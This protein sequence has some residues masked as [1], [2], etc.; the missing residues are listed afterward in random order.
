MAARCQQHCKRHAPPALLLHAF[1]P[2]GRG[3]AAADAW[4]GCQQRQQLCGTRR[5]A[6]AAALLLECM[7][8][9]ASRAKG[10]HPKGR[11]ASRVKPGDG[12]SLPLPRRSITAAAHRVISSPSRSTTG[13]ST[14]S[15]NNQATVINPPLFNSST[16]HRAA[17]TGGHS[18]PPPEDWVQHAAPARAGAT[19]QRHA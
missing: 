4:Q 7:L 17:R 19:L 2:A 12:L 1:T 6:C 9:R 14:C 3:T 11:P 13:F 15:T 8:Q 5:P 16:G 18:W 10:A